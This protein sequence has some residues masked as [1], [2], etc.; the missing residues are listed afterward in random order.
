MIGGLSHITLIVKDIEKTAALFKHILGAEI[1]YSSGDKTFSISREIFLS[2][3]GLWMALMQGESLK[4]RTYNHIAFKVA[5]GE[6]EQY[7]KKIKEAG[8]EIKEGRNRI[9][10]EAD[11][12]YSYD[13]DNHLFEIHSG[14]L[15]DRLKAY[16]R[17]I[18]E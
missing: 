5:P 11:S 18:A 7:F 8:L 2:I 10:G 16:G 1:I 13:Y 9:S 12:I 6:F 17:S 4:E 14:T 3:N 15:E